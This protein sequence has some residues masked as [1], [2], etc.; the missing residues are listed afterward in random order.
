MS[1]PLFCG[2]PMCK[3]PVA[4][5][6]SA[7]WP[8]YCP[9][10]HASLYPNDE[11]ERLAANE[12]APRAMPLMTDAGGSRAPVDSKQLQGKTPKAAKAPEADL[13]RILQMVDVDP[14]ANAA[15]R[16]TRVL[17]IVAAVGILV[18]IALLLLLRH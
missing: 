4:V 13:D 18:L 6:A 14:R 12:L 11:L 8:F 17:A 7:R 10:C 3:K 5:P 15:R 9:S 2:D 16:R 1:T